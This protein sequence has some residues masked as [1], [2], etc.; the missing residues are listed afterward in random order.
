MELPHRCCTIRTATSPGGRWF[1][2]AEGNA[3]YWLPADNDCFE[4]LSGINLRLPF[5]R[6]WRQSIAIG[7]GSA[8]IF[9]HVFPAVVFD[10]YLFSA[11]GTTNITS[12]AGHTEAAVIFRRLLENHSAAFRTRDFHFAIS[13]WNGAVATARGIRHVFSG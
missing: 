4:G 12:G 13:P 9:L 7:A 1:F 3:L 11:N 10:N 5:D 8:D 6:H 2:C